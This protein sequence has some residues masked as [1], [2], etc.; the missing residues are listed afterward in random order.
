[1]AIRYTAPRDLE[2]MSDAAGLFFLRDAVSH[3]S[4]TAGA[5]VRFPAEPLVDPSPYAKSLQMLRIRVDDG[6]LH[7]FV[8]GEHLVVTGNPSALESFTGAL[9]SA[10][11]GAPGTHVHL[12]HYDG[13]PRIDPK[14]V[15]LVVTQR[16]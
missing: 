4:T 15:P 3:V 10:A 12:E 5:S 1:M 11:S 14:S 13:H 8:L 7:V 16:R 9:H 6:L 2:L